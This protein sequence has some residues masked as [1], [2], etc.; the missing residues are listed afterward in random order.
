[1]LLQKYPKYLENCL[2]FKK[3]IIFK[4]KTVCSTFLCNFWGNWATFKSSIWS[5]WLLRLESSM[6]F[7]ENEANMR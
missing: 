5:H 3:R 6:K 1:M 2:D 4:V 7:N